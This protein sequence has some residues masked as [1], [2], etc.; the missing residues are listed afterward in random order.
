MFYLSDNVSCL[1]RNSTVFQRSTW[2][3]LTFEVIKENVLLQSLLK[4]IN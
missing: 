4:N 3:K 2:I 1:N